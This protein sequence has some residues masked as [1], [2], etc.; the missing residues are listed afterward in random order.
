MITFRRLYIAFLLWAGRRLGPYK[1][2]NSC[3]DRPFPKPTVHSLHSCGTVEI[4]PD[5]MGGEPSSH[6]YPIL[7]EEEEEEEEDDDDD[8]EFLLLLSLSRTLM[9]ARG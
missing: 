7:Q 8:D 1:P 6:N 4:G 9:L 2:S 3:T 5:Q